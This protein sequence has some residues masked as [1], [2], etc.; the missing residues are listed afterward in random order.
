MTRLKHGLALTNRYAA[1]RTLR[2]ALLVLFGMPVF[3]TALMLTSAEVLGQDKWMVTPSRGG[4]EGAKQNAQLTTINNEFSRMNA[5]TGVGRIYAPTHPSADLSGCVTEVA[6]RSM[7]ANL[8]VGGAAQVSGS[9]TIGG[10]LSVSGP[11]MLPLGVG[12]GVNP[13]ATALDIGGAIKIAGT[14]ETCDA[15]KPGAIRYNPSSQQMEFCNGT[16]WGPMGGGPVTGPVTGSITGGC[17]FG[18]GWGTAT[19]C[20]L[21]AGIIGCSA[22]NTGRP[23]TYHSPSGHGQWNSVGTYASGFC[24]KD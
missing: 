13:P 21:S 23:I 14:S 16:T 1:R 2:R 15:S 12:V 8:A 4:A 5:C 7:A 24:I 18:R 17:N 19:N 20:A 9:V 6:G 10:G 22:G 11:V 3:F